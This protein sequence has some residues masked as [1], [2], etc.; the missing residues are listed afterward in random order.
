MA[1]KKTPAPFP[2]PLDAAVTFYVL[3]VAEM[4]ISNA[5]AFEK[6]IAMLLKRFPALTP[7]QAKLVVRK[8]VELL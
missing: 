5:L 2:S 6:T 4:Q 3:L 7:L 8:A 1:T